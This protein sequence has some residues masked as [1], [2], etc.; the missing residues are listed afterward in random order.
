MLGYTVVGMLLVKLSV[1][2]ESEPHRVACQLGS[3]IH[4]KSICNQYYGLAGL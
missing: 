3:K 2:G 4:V 1:E